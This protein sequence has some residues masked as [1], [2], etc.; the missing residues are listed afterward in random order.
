MTAMSR[1]GL[2]VL[3]LLLMGLTGLAVLAVNWPRLH[4]PSPNAPDEDVRGSVRNGGP[5]AGARVRFQGSAVSAVTEADGS[6]RLPPAPAGAARAT[7]AREGYLIA[8]AAA[9]T[10]PLTLTLLPL[11]REDNEEY[12]WVSSAPGAGSHNCGNCHEEIYREWS[13]SAHARA[14]AGR[15]FLNLYDGGDWDGRPNTGWSLLRDNP[16]GAGVCNSCHAPTM[17]FDSASYFDIRRARGVAAE[18]VH[19]DYCHKVQGVGEGPLG[20]SHGRFNLRLLRPTE[21]QLFF[22]PL[23]DVDRGDDTFSPLYHDSRYCASCHEGTVFG[24]AVYTTYSEWQASPAARTGKQC[25]TCHMAPTGRMTNLAPGHGGIDREPQTLANHRFFAGSPRDMLRAA[26]TLEASAHQRD[27]AARV[28]VEVRADGA[29]HRLPTGYIDRHLLLVVEAV[30]ADDRPLPPAQGPVLPPAAG[31]ALAGQPGKL[32]A[33]LLKDFDGHSPAPFWKADPDPADTRLT[34][35]APDRATFVFPDATARVR[36]RLL[37]R[38]F[39]QQVAD[40]KRWPDNEIV[41]AERQ[42]S[43]PRKKG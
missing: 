10:S 14:A 40:E 18:G 16:D 41:V 20:L 21:G 4:D 30:D 5:V 35:G 6:F 12:H 38:R 15:H 2:L 31:K 23:D 37:Y 1:T 36:L 8:G 33:R 32:Y 25:H 34:P 17:P 43:I 19:C 7:A 28:E 3:T 29:G 24:V 22:G 9:D 39:W 27:G 42:V 11:P 13:A 26:V